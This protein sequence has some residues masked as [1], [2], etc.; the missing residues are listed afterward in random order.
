[1]SKTHRINITVLTRE[2]LAP[3]EAGDLVLF[4]GTIY[5]GRDAAHKRMVDA[6]QK[7]ENLPMDIKGQVMYYVGPTPPAPGRIIGAAGPTTSYRMDAYTPAL[8]EQG[9][10]AMIGKG[11]RSEEVKAAMVKHGAIYLAAIGGAGALLSQAIKEAEV[12]AFDD[13]GPEAVRRLR[14]EDFP[15]TVINDLAGNDLYEQ[16]RKIYAVQG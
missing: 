5:T 8:L 14:V 12:I 1:M 3:L 16:G 11:R 7:G 6:L 9:L 4:S 10:A 2:T 15:A 13:L